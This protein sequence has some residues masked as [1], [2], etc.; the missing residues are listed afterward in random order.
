MTLP[1]VAAAVVPAAKI[2]DYLLNPAHPDGAGKAKFFTSLGFSRSDWEQLAMA[3]RRLAER[4]PV[5]QTLES[6]HGTKYIVDG[7]LETP[8]GA[9]PVVRSVW[10][11]DHGSD[12]PRLVTAY[13]HDEG[14]P[15]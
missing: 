11:V 2:V 4:F 13:P 3:L 14:N 7:P 6:A 10:I 8:G 1:N 9:T 5:G 15:K 12:V